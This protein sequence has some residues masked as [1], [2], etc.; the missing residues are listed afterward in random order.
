MLA[1]IAITRPQGC[2][3][4]PPHITVDALA[5]LARSKGATHHHTFTGPD[6]RRWFEW[7]QEMPLPEGTPMWPYPTQRSDA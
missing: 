6:G 2:I 7:W 4:E 5:A 1:P 3:E